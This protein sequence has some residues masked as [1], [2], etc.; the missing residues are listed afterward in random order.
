MRFHLVIA[1]WGDKYISHL[2]N[3]G[4]HT[5][6]A[7]NNLGALP[8]LSESRFIF[9]VPER[10]EVTLRSQ[11]MI[12]R[13]HQLI[14]VTYKRI[15]PAQFSEPHLALSEAHRQSVLDA[16]ADGAHLVVLSP[17]S[18]MSDGTLATVGK[19]AAEGRAAIMVTGLRLVEET[20]VPAL[21][22]IFADP[23]QAR[24]IVDARAMIRFATNHFH[25]EVPRYQVDS[26][27]FTPH[28][29][30]CLWPI[31]GRGLLQRAFHL[32]PLL[33]D[34]TRIPEK[35]L[36]ALAHDTIDGDFVMR[37]FP[38]LADVVV[39]QDSDEVLMFS[40]SS[41]RDHL[42]PMVPNKFTLP[43]LQRTAYRDNVNALHRYLFTQPIRLHVDDLDET[44]RKLEDETASIALLA[45]N[46]KIDPS[47]MTE[48][49]DKNGMA[50]IEVRPGLLEKMP[51]PHMR[52]AARVA[53]QLAREGHYL[54]LMQKVGNRLRRSVGWT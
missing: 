42:S 47:V 40:F 2:S 11:P 49:T 13:L 1:V 10:D 48:G 19:R 38:N 27:Y 5:L 29:L 21:R 26:E 20:A 15:E 28:P 18:I 50:S 54:K 33:I 24:E 46:I 8:R 6:L 30:L 45:S 14:N 12:Q 37:A 31:K 52:S 22:A 17:D 44:W 51:F 4:L 7:P 41:S 34:A 23:N 39:E 36:R 16:A 25:P 9:Y 3:V 53:L 32:H 43:L 35:S